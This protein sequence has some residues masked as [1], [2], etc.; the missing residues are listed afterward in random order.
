M[1]VIWRDSLQPKEYKPLRYRKFYILGTPKGWAITVPGDNNLYK[2]HYCAQNAID[3]H[4]GDLG[5]HGTEKRKR[6]GIQ[7]VGTKTDGEGVIA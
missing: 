3:A 4:Y 6:Y 5:A 7:I 1:R 2:T